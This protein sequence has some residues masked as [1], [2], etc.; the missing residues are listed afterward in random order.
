M[1][2][3]ENISKIK[4][5]IPKNVTLVAVSKTQSVENILEAYNTG[6]KIF[7]ENKVQELLEKFSWYVKPKHF[8]SLL[9]N[10][11]ISFICDS[12]QDQ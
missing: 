10:N 6:H 8:S 3:A 11:L 7:G 2:I 5:L 12:I 9:L 4:T 1:S